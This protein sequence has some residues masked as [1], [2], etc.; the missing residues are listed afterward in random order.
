MRRFYLSLIAGLIVSCA[1]HKPGVTLDENVVDP[2]PKGIPNSS[3]RTV[4]IARAELEK[5]TSSDCPVIDI[6]PVTNGT[7]VVFFCELR[8]TFVF[9]DSQTKKA[10]FIG[11]N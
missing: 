8:P 5:Q 3:I 2:I 1:S 11:S 10:R 6:K 7:I 4:S 9:V